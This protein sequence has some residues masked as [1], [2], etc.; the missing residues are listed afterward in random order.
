MPAPTDDPRFPHLRVCREHGRP[1]DPAPHPERGEQQTC[2]GDAAAEKWPR[3]DF[4]EWVHLCE[5]CLQD[6]TRSGSRFSTFFCDTCCILLKA[7]APQVP[8]G[9]HSLLSGAALP[10]QVD[11]TKRRLDDMFAAID[12]LHAWSGVRLAEI[13]AAGDGDPTLADVMAAARGRGDKEAALAALVAH[14]KG[15]APDS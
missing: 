3:F 9:R 2:H 6:T 8:M 13:V 4:N 1:Y 10:P 14:W 11:A 7:R 5:C 12:A 15:R